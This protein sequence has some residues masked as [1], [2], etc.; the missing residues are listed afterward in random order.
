MVVLAAGFLLFMFLINLVVLCGKIPHITDPNEKTSNALAILFVGIASV[1]VIY[2][3]V[4]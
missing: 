3:A 1:A 4:N 2:L